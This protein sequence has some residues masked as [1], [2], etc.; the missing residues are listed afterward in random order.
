MQKSIAIGGNS[1]TEP[2]SE[3]KKPCLLLFDSFPETGVL[4][5]AF[6]TDIIA[7]ASCLLVPPVYSLH[8]GSTKN[9][10][11]PAL[12]F[13]AKFNVEHFQIQYE[14]KKGAILTMSELKGFTLMLRVELLV[15]DQT[16]V[17]CLKAALTCG[18]NS[19]TSWK[20][21]VY[22]HRCSLKSLPPFPSTT[23]T[24]LCY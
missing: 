24:S 23:V 5:F 1:P 19:E 16:L 4:S 15:R 21:C 22:F 8:L 12:F 7:A 14:R 3:F 20:I 13:P 9:T 10:H 6:K 18:K 2:Y 11:G 17:L